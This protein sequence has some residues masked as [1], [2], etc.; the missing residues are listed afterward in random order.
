MTP[1]TE[2]QVSYELPGQTRKKEM[3]G[4]GLLRRGGR[5]AAKS[6]VSVSLSLGHLE[7]ESQNGRVESIRLRARQTRSMRLEL[8]LGR[9][10]SHGRLLAGMLALLRKSHL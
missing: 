10:G 4:E 7:E 8:V 9:V 1:E 5:H 6:R 2:S 3:L